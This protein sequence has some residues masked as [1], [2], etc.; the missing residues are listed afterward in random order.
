MERDRIVDGRSV[1]PG[2]VLVGLPSSGLHTNGYSLAR[3]VLFEVAG[4]SPNDS[5]PGLGASVGNALLAVHKSYL[6][7][8]GP[9]LEAGLVKAMAHVTGG[10]I[11]ENL[12]RS[13][14]A[15]CDALVD[16]RSW[17]VPPLFTLVQQLGSIADAEM[18]RAFNMGVG[19]VLTCGATELGRV[20][21]LLHASGEPAF[22]MGRVEAGRGIVRYQP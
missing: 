6:I 16:R 17:A 20:L 14:P 10:G 1:V 9:L 22:A 13:L 12:P 2:D 3:R 4:L 7:P 18:L 5:P 19:L 11:T 15:S 21:E 8:V